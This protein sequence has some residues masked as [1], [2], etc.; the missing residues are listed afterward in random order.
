VID[1]ALLDLQKLEQPLEAQAPAASLA[2]VVCSN[3]SV[4]YCA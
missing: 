1:V 2:S 4:V 3:F